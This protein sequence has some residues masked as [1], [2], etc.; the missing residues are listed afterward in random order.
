MTI[1]IIIDEKNSVHI[2]IFYFS[3]IS[4]SFLV[5]RYRETLV[6]FFV[7]TD[8]EESSVAF[9][10]IYDCEEVPEIDKPLQR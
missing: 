3:Q 7:I 8:V 6:Q 5:V 2:P 4:I 10:V 9:P 1:F